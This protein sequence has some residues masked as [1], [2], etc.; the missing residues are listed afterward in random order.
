MR[1]EG[2]NPLVTAL[3]ATVAPAAA[4]RHSRQKVG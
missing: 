2:G 4:T 1:G 3:A